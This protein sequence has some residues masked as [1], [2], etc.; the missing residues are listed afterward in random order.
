MAH[1][2]TETD[3]KNFTVRLNRIAGQVNG[4]N[5][6]ISEDRDCIEVLNQILSTQSALRGIWKQ[7]VRCHLEH[8]VTDALKNNKNSDE[9]IDELVEHIDKIR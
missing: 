9:I 1:C 7:V 6:M 2:Y 4:I 5:K 3:K 8:C